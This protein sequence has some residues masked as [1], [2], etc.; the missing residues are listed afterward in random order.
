[1]QTRA[2]R[3]HPVKSDPRSK[4]IRAGHLIDGLGGEPVDNVA[5]GI[6]GSKIATIRPWSEEM[7]L[8]GEVYD[9]GGR[10]VLP[11]LVDAHCHLTLQARAL[12][13]AQEMT[14][15]DEFMAVTAIHNLGVMLESGVT[16]LRDNGGRGSIVFAV[17]SAVETGLA[18]GPR[19]LLAGRPITSTGG[20]FHFCGGVADSAE[21]IQR[22]VRRLVAEGADHIK[23]MAS[24]GGTEGTNPGLS[25][26]TGQ[27]LKAAVDAA[28][29]YGRLTTAHCLASRSIM[30]AIEA[31]LDCIEHA[32][33][34]QPAALVKNRET[35]YRMF[36]HPEQGLPYEEQWDPVIAERLLASGVFVSI[37]LPGSRYTVYGRLMEKRGT[38]R[39]SREERAEYDHGKRMQEARAEH[40]HRFLEIGMLPRLVISSDAGPYDIEF[41]KL[42][43]G[44]EVAIAGGMTQMQTLE[45]CTRVAAEAC[46]VLDNVGTIEVGKEADLLITFQ[47]PLENIRNLA[48]VAAVFKAGELVVVREATGA[49]E[50]S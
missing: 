39:L 33:F 16:T 14:Y 46:G 6:Q 9:F 35:S 7:G 36:E 3:S 30:Y 29:S 48:G 11:G 1:M 18:K 34:A 2:L 17:R 25:S 5:I 47:S 37:T 32:Q 44:L 4:V 50:L 13:Y 12:S 8:Y 10:T 41:G 38:Q 22:E 21:E 27:E 42:Y 26:Y 40:V 31:G 45:S 28:H 43:Q 19:L 49:A 24:G 23:I 20:H 15:S